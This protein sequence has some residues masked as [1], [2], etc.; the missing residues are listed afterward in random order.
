MLI[1]YSQR[2]HELLYGPLRVDEKEEL[3]GVFHRVGIGLGIPELPRNYTAWAVD[4]QQH[5]RADLECSAGTRALLARY[6]EELGGWRYR[7]LL[8]VQGVLAPKHVRDLLKLN[9]SRWL[10]VC[11]RLYPLFVRMGLRSAIQRTLMPAR[12]LS[13]VVALDSTPAAAG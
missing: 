5:L 3:Y 10:R 4:R 7:L 6:R 9:R 11:V 1:D 8:R 2:A 13:A 12:H